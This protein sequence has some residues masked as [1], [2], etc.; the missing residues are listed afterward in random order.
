VKLPRWWKG[1]RVS[2]VDEDARKALVQARE[3]DEEEAPVKVRGDVDG[4]P[5]YV[6]EAEYGEQKSAGWG[7]V[8]A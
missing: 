5:E 7:D 2:W 8:L 3:F 6:L 1:K 4:A